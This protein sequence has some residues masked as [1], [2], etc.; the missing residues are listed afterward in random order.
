MC[1]WVFLGGGGGVGCRLGAFGAPGFR[2]AGRAERVAGED[3]TIINAL[4]MT[5][6]DTYFGR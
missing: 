2:A 6:V 5:D 4:T 1:V 3:F